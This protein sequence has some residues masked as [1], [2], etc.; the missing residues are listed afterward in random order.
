MKNVS[1]TA[2]CLWGD[3]LQGITVRSFWKLIFLKVYSLTTLN[4]GHNLVPVHIEVFWNFT[5][6]VFPTL[7]KQQL[8]FLTTP[9]FLPENTHSIWFMGIWVLNIHFEMV[10]TLIKFKHFYEICVNLIYSNYHSKWHVIKSSPVFKR[11][12]QWNYMKYNIFSYLN[13]G[14]LLSWYVMVLDYLW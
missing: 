10:R 6:Y 5:C 8:C 14:Y 11:V 12:E 1:S 13:S 4:C 9:R 7:C 2:S 3:N